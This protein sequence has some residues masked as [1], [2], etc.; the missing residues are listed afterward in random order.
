[1]SH[2]WHIIVCKQDP[3]PKCL[4]TMHPAWVRECFSLLTNDT[5]VRLN[6]FVYA[7]QC[8]IKVRHAKG[9]ETVKNVVVPNA[10]SRTTTV[11]RFGENFDLPV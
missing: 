10:P 6:H 9:S 8:Q 5:K 7:D 4:Q 3:K 1:M 2:F 11:P